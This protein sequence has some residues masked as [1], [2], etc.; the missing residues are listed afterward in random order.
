MYRAA[1]PDGP[2]YSKL[3]LGYSIFGIGAVLSVVS[4]TVLRI[5]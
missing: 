2:L 4:A 3:V 5:S 1:Y